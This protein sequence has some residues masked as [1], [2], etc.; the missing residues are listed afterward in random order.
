MHRWCFKN[1]TKDSHAI[2]T[3]KGD[4]FQRNGQI[5][6]KEMN[7]I[8][9]KLKRG[10]EPSGIRVNEEDT[11]IAEHSEVQEALLEGLLQPHGI[12]PNTKQD[13]TFQLLCENPNGLNN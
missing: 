11:Q 8:I 12:L 5:H 7:E 1:R 4:M 6:G 9:T 3:K 13:G 10:E 2:L